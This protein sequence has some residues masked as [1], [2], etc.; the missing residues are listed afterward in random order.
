MAKGRPSNS[1]PMGMLRWSTRLS[2]W[3]LINYATVPIDSKWC[4]KGYVEDAKWFGCRLIIRIHCRSILTIRATFY[5][6]KVYAPVPKA[7]KCH[8]ELMVKDSSRLDKVCLAELLMQSADRANGAYGRYQE[9]LR[10]IWGLHGNFC[11]CQILHEASVYPYIKKC[12]LQPMVRD[13]NRLNL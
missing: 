7:I 2:E 5:H 1:G 8:L 3:P 13:I 10:A 6:A 9:P 11:L 12:Y 4:F